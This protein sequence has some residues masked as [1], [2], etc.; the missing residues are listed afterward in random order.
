MTLTV[1][2]CC[3]TLSNQPTY[4]NPYNRFGG[5]INLSF[6]SNQVEKQQLILKKEEYAKNGLNI[7][8]TYL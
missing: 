1:L 7:I 2:M 6:S 8:I 3:K 5:I 4:T